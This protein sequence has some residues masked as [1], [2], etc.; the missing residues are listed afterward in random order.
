MRT[1]LISRTR[2]A[3]ASPAAPTPAPKSATRS[4]GRAAVA[5]ASNIA[6]WPARWPLFGWRRSNCA[7]RKASSVKASDGSVI[8][9]QF[10]AEAGIGEHL[11]RLAIV[12]IADQDAPRQHAERALDHTHVL[13][14]HHMMDVGA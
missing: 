11:S 14:Q 1:R 9:P 5:A 12:L 6:S 4:P 13:V 7:P 3:T 8:G 2:L 10:M